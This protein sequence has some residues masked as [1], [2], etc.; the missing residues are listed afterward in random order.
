VAVV[1]VLLPR[2]GITI[3]TKE[4]ER[5]PLPESVSQ[6]KV[7]IQGRLMW[8]FVDRLKREREQNDSKA[9]WLKLSYVLV[10]VGLGLV[11]LAGTTA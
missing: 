2:P 9:R 8:G 10:C 7:M 11:S 1:K 4:V 3:S 6:D 5:Y